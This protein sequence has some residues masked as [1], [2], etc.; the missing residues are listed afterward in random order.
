MGVRG[1]RRRGRQ[2][3]D[4]VARK[5]ERAGTG[6]TWGRAAEE[7]GRV[8]GRLHDLSGSHHLGQFQIIRDQ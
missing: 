2:G 6:R 3:D 8:Q 5:R 7:E 4:R 1:K